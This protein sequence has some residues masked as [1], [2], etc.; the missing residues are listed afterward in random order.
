MSAGEGDPLGAFFAATLSF[1]SN[2]TKDMVKACG[3][4]PDADLIQTNGSL[5]QNHLQKLFSRTSEAYAGTNQATRAAVGEY[6]ALADGVFVASTGEKTARSSL[7]KGIFGGGFF[8]WISKYLTEIKKIIRFIVRLIFGRVPDWLEELLVLIDQIWGMLA[9]LLGGVFG[10]N[11]RE[12]A[13]DISSGEINS[14]NEIAA[15]QRLKAV[16]RELDRSD[17]D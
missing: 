4:D 17:D 6:L 16:S 12:I 8:S 9:E 13:R 7:A 3:S 15:M 1:V 11:R 5:V 14:L 10:F 2:V